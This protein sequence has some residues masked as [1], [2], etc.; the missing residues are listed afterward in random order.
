MT[1]VG[2][3][4][5]LVVGAICGAI[6]ESIVG[7]SAGGFLASA[8]VGFLGTLIGT[9]LARVLGLPSLLAVRIQTVTIEVVWAVL[10]AVILL[11]LVSVVRRSQYGRVY[12]G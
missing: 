10:G 5:L 3:L 7:W 4:L 6:A 8:G 9:W 12:R 2:L 1:I 11:T